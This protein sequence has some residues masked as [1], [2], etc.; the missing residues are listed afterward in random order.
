[1][2]PH[3][4]VVAALALATLCHSPVLCGFMRPPTHSYYDTVVADAHAR[5]AAN[6]ASRLQSWK[7]PFQAIS[8]KGNVSAS[9]ATLAPDVGTGEGAITTFLLQENASEVRLAQEYVAVKSGCIG[10]FYMCEWSRAVVLS[11]R[12]AGKPTPEADRLLKQNMLNYLTGQGKLNL[13]DETEGDPMRQWASENLDMVRRQTSYLYFQVLAEDPAWASQVILNK[14]VTEHYALWETFFYDQLKIRATQGLF[15]ELASNNY[16][17][18]TW[19]CM[20]NLLDMPSSA[21][22]RQRARMFVD[23]AFTE[24]EQFGLHGV[25]GGQ[26]SRS[27]KDDLGHNSGLFGTMYGSIA[28]IFYGDNLTTTQKGGARI[29]TLETQRDY[30]MSNVSVLMHELGKS[31]ETGGSYAVRNRMLGQ[32]DPNRTADGHMFAYPSDQVHHV[33]MTP[34]YSLG[35]VEFFPKK[36]SFIANTQLRWTGLIFG[37]PEFTTISLPH[38]TG[39]KWSMVDRDVLI[40]QRCKTCYYGGNPGMQVAHLTGR[41]LWTVNNWTFFEALNATRTGQSAWA[42]VRPAWGGFKPLPRPAMPH[43]CHVCNCQVTAG[44]YCPGHCFNGEC[45]KVGYNITSG[46]FWSNDF[47]APLIFVVGEEK[48]FPGGAD[49][50]ANAVLDAPLT[51]TNT[52]LNGA[53]PES[54]VFEWRARKYEFF[55]MNGTKESYRLPEINGVPMDT[56]PDFTYQGPHLNAPLNGDVVTLSYTKDYAIKYDFGSDTVTRV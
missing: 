35:A 38:S 44:R 36:E 56:S 55:P 41:N 21:R 16:W 9:C 10:G 43:G 45:D 27:K 24:A 30:Q 54:V 29:I 5:G 34:S 17:Y 39:E 50:F 23:I 15:V 37:N 53:V 1:M 13:A 25:R 28:P 33:E 14:T 32:F 20:A 11:Q 4:L 3:T 52:S 18:R 48:N 8:I 31:P 49:G 2:T 51:V 22:V 7:R 6:L 46:M 26:K 40:N 42:A 19:P 47:F 12:T